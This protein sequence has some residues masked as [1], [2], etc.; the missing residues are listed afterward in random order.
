M[1]KLFNFT[2]IAS[3]IAFILSVFTLYRPLVN[4]KDSTIETLKEQIALLEKKVTH[5]SP[6]ILLTSVSKR[7]EI[8][9]SEIE[10]LSS[11]N[12]NESLKNREQGIVQELQ[13][14]IAYLEDRLM[15]KLE[16]IFKEERPF[17]DLTRYQ[18]FSFRRNKIEYCRVIRVAAQNI[19]DDTVYGIKV[20]LRD[21]SIGAE[22]YDGIPLR[23]KDDFTEIMDPTFNLDPGEI[24]YVD[25]ALRKEPDV[26]SSDCTYLRIAAPA[27]LNSFIGNLEVKGLKVQLIARGHPTVEKK[28]D[29]YLEEYPVTHQDGKQTFHKLLRCRVSSEAI[30]T[31]SEVNLNSDKLN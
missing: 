27:Y 16:L 30:D 18:H 29:I 14:T 3:I 23:P 26:E 6:D 19:G 21:F 4:Q 12:S 11:S 22:S 28:L 1:D 25:I 8:A 24:K 10:R 20:V 5:T 31:P 9:I 17:E 7:L 13:N 2:T 15:P